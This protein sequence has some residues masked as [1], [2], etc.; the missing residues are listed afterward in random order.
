MALA[1]PSLP[2]SIMSTPEVGF[3]EGIVDVASSRGQ[4]RLVLQPLVA[5]LVGVRLG[6]A[7]AKLGDTPFLL[8]LA[9]RRADRRALLAAAA[10]ELVLPFSI[11]IVLDGVLQ[12]LT[13]GRVRPLAAIV[14]GILLIWI[15]FSL[16]RSLTTRYYRRRHPELHTAAA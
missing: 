16:S 5:L 13:L 9:T 10:K 8:R 2:A 1:R 7:D 11:A 14:M 15:P 3:W 4:L 6:V 12:F